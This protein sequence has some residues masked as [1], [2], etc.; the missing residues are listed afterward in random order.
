[1]PPGLRALLPIAV[2][3]AAL[4][5]TLAMGADAPRVAAEDRLESAVLAELNL[6]RLEHGLKQLAR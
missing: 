2:T 4:L 1:M 6:V 3:V 5:P